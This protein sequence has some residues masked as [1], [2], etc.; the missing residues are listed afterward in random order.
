[1]FCFFFYEIVGYIKYFG[2]CEQR[3]TMTFN[4]PQMISQSHSFQRDF[5]AESSLKMNQNLKTG[6]KT[7][8]CLISHNNL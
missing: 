4:F 3:Q 5:A 8:L 6:K 1:M 7:N 2:I